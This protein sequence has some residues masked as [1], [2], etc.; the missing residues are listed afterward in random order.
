MKPA[1]RPTPPEVLVI[2]TVRD[3]QV[4]VEIANVARELDDAVQDLEQLLGSTGPTD[5]V[6]AASRRLTALLAKEKAA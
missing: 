4:A 3:A 2:E 5:R 6:K 1:R